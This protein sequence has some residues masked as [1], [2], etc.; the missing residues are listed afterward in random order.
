MDIEV[1]I[2]HGGNVRVHQQIFRLDF[3]YPNF[4]IIDSPGTVMRILSE[5]GDKY[6]S[7]YQDDSTN[8]KVV[9]TSRDEKKGT[10]RQITVA[11]T[12]LTYIFESSEG[13]NLESLDANET[14]ATLFKGVQAILEKFKIN[15]IERAGIRFVILGSIKEGNPKL[16]SH[17]CNLADKTIIR[18]I[19]S[20]LGSISDFGLSFDGQAADKLKYHCHLGPYS[21]ITESKKRFNVETSKKMEEDGLLANLILDLDFYEEKFAMTVNAA[22]WSKAPAIKAIKL[23]KEI[24]MNLFE[25]L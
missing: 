11:P 24:E 10:L 20:N 23:A 22:K 17:F 14:L 21:S 8:R 13:V 1:P 12:V 7:E 2:F 4:D 16:E 25:R 5:M 19:T 9:T 3:Q 18:D 15:D 6:W